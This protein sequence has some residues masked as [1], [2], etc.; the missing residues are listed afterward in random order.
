MSR[1][2]VYLLEQ[3]PQPRERCPECG[4]PLTDYPS[5]KECDYCGYC[6]EGGRG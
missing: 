2:T 5:C 3:D 1:R 6:D 4:L